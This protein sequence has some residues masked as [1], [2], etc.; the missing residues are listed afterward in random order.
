MMQFSLRQGKGVE[1]G[2]ERA[3]ELMSYG[4]ELRGSDQKHSRNHA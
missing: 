1:G 4:A 2:L 3:R